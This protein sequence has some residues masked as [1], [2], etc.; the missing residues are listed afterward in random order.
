MPKTEL[1]PGQALARVGKP[2]SGTLGI[3]AISV[4]AGA[5]SC[6]PPAMLPD[7]TRE[8]TGT[9]FLTSLWQALAPGVRVARS[10]PGHAFGTRKADRCACRRGC[11]PSRVAACAVETCMNVLSFKAVCPCKRS[12]PAL[13]VAPIAREARRDPGC[14]NHPGCVS[15]TKAM[16]HVKHGKTEAWASGQDRACRLREITPCRRNSGSAPRA[17]P[18]WPPQGDHQELPA[19]PHDEPTGQ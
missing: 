6:I 8:D 19:M 10:R 1:T 17:M 12:G 15:R 9:L 18:L 13:T 11:H 14:R 2:R 16:F 4:G 7:A 5:R 3:S